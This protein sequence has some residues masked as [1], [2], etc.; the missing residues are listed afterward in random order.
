MECSVRQVIETGTGGG[1]ANLVIC[2]I[3][4]LH[5]D[6]AILDEDGRIDPNKLRLV[7]RLG[8]DYYVDAF[9]EGLFKLQ[10]PG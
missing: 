4:M 7:G 2:E 6:E 5:V 10:K 9:G 3:L 8:G 1:S